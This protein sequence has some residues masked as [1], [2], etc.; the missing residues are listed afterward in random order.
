M[1][2]TKSLWQQLDSEPKHAFTETVFVV[3]QDFNVRRVKATKPEGRSGYRVLETGRH[4]PRT[5]WFLDKTAAFAYA[6]G[7]IKA[8]VKRAEALTKRIT[9]AKIN[10]SSSYGQLP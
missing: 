4:V 6:E 3:T 8:M 9:K 10:L 2:A 5:E 7:K 1:T